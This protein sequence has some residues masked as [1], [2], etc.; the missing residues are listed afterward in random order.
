[1]VIT[2]LT[3]V[4]IRIFDLIFSIFALFILSPLFLIC[5]IVLRLS[6]EGEVFF[7]QERIGKNNSTF[8]IFKFATMLKNSPNLENGTITIVNDYR[9]LPIGKFLRNSKINELPQLL[10]VIKGDMSLIGYRPLVK[11]DIEGYT[12]KDLNLITVMK[13]GLSGLSS[14]FF[15]DENKFFN[16]KDPRKIYR[17]T[18]SPIKKEIDLWYSKNY[19][20]KN[21]FL[22]IY[23]TIIIL[24]SKRKRILIKYYPFLR[25]YN[26][27]L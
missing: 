5:I 17:E 2:K 22:L 23:L 24:L 13:P 1:M 7:L 25:K 21:Y 18:I 6:G 14:I 9:V 4:F 3:R 15:S 26:K 20:I 11:Q 27:F 12:K 10:N 8:H 19:S 16:D